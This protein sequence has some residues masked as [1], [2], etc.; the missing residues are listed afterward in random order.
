MEGQFEQIKKSLDTGFTNPQ[1]KAIIKFLLSF[2]NDNNE[3]S[4]DH[5]NYLMQLQEK[6]NL[7]TT[8]FSLAHHM[9]TSEAILILGKLSPEH[10]TI[11]GYIF[12]TMMQLDG[13]TYKDKY[14]YIKVLFL[15]IG[16]TTY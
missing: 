10:K 11:A 6:W 16:I 1:V 5:A 2:A 15:Q 13:P 4:D 14:Q 9:D 8:D 7:T 3:I 12:H